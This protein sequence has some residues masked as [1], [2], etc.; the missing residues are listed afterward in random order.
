LIWNV[1][2]TNRLR[3]MPSFRLRCASCPFF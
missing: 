1:L 3:H 2:L